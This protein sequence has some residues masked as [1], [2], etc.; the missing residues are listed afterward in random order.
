MSKLVNKYGY[1]LQKIINKQRAT[2][3]EA[4]A[5]VCEKAQIVELNLIDA[6]NKGENIENSPKLFWLRR[7]WS[8]LIETANSGR[9]VN[10]DGFVLEDEIINLDADYLDG[11]VTPKIPLEV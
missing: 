2:G 10:G 4:V 5:L 6:D 1:D 3:N 11:K 8:R 9:D 7:F